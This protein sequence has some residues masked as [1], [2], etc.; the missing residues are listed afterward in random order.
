MRKRKILITCAM[1]VSLL[2][3][4][5][6]LSWAA[7]EE[8][9][10][11]EIYET[12]E[13]EEMKAISAAMDEEM[14]EQERISEEWLEAYEREWEEEGLYSEEVED[15]TEEVFYWKGEAYAVGELFEDS[16]FQEEATMLEDSF[17][18][19][20]PYTRTETAGEVIIDMGPDF[21]RLELQRALYEEHE[22]RHLIVNVPAG[23][24]EMDDR[25]YVKS[26]TTLHSD[27]EAIYKRIS[28]T[29]YCTFLSSKNDDGDV[30]GYDQIQNVSIIGGTFDGEYQK[31]QM[32]RFTHGNNIAVQDVTFIHISAGG[33][34]LSL[35]GVNDVEVDNCHFVGFAQSTDR[36]KKEA[37]HID[38]V[39]NATIAPG[40]DN[41]DDTACRNITVSNC[42]F[43]DVSRGVGS[44]SAVK[45][46]FTSNV[47]IVNNKFEN[48]YYEAIKTINYKDTVISNNQIDNC[49]N[50]IFVH[51]RLVESSFYDP[52]PGTVTE[53]VPSA[54]DQY[55]YNITVQGN[56]IK[57][58][59]GYTN[60]AD[61]SYGIMVRGDSEYPLGGIQ[62]IDN[63][64]GTENGSE[65][66]AKGYGVH[67]NLYAM[68][69]TVSGNKIMST[70][71]VG[72]NLMNNSD[73]NNI[74]GNE[75]HYPG[76]YGIFVENCDSARVYSN[77]VVESTRSSFGFSKSPNCDIQE[78]RS[79]SSHAG[80]I[81]VATNSNSPTIRKNTIYDPN[82][83]GIYVADT[84]IVKVLTN[85]LQRIRNNIGIHVRDCDRLNT[86]YNSFTNTTKTPIKLLRVTKA[87]T[88]SLELIKVNEI[89]AGSTRVRGTAGKA[90]STVTVTVNEKDYKTVVAES[91]TFSSYLIPAMS[92]GTKVVVTEKDVKGNMV[93]AAATVA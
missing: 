50:G 42:E 60:E 41:Y 76:A 4:M 84:N 87:N 34:M 24:H 52:L 12:E 56:T 16:G 11:T 43:K 32:M 5:P 82:W 14:R 51:T 70:G 83:Y 61:E 45:G 80:G 63:Q 48:V 3:S 55:N 93:K 90:G 73:N 10:E 54:E 62:V 44:H 7:V 66:G 58:I 1:T 40:S 59:Q 29:G 64:I 81:S 91:R 33:H 15:E 9:E 6:G 39:H 28:K 37:I 67:L 13:T 75:I 89:T 86:S 69:C 47:S 21:T 85:T 72:I 38:V 65:P 79:K 19:E 49:G 18:A 31:G 2:F 27:A 68:Y 20:M 8:A 22:G 46:V 26:D 35:E 77:R 88:T 78:N 25:V 17:L 30:G 71:L 57:N 92:K 23:V 53:K 74:E 36:T